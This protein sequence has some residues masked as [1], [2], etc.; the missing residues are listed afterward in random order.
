MKI[1]IEN[2]SVGQKTVL[3]RLLE[4]YKYD[5]SEYD[6]EDVNEYGEYGY[7]YLDHYWT[8]PERFPFLIKV[9]EKFAGFALVRKITHETLHKEYYFSMAEFFIMKKF[10]KEGIGKH[11]AFYLFDLFPGNWEVAEIEENVPA[12]TFWRKVISEYT[13][14]NY[15]EIQRI[16]W[17]GPIQIFKTKNK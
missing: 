4:F 3:R 7:K 15:K 16:N 8:E 13:K 14:D 9:N 10:R 5:F 6:P 17:K 1:Q 11:T 2:A 12:Q